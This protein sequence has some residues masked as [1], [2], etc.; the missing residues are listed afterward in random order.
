MI[1]KMHIIQGQEETLTKIVK[2]IHMQE[3]YICLENFNK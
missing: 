2:N 3:E 1:I